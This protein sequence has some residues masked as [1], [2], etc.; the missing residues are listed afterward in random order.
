MSPKR[1]L[2]FLLPGLAAAG[3]LLLWLA[4]ARVAEFLVNKYGG[5]ALTAGRV[6]GGGG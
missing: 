1:R 5:A 4:Q 2:L 6:E 3:V